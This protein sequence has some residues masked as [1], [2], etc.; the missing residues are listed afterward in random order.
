MQ[1]YNPCEERSFYGTL[2]SF[3]SAILRA[4]ESGLRSRF[5]H[6]IIESGHSEL[7]AVATINI[8]STR[9]IENIHYDNGTNKCCGTQQITAIKSTWR[10][11]LIGS[12]RTS[13]LDFLFCEEY[14]YLIYN[15]V[16]LL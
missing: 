9:D 6:M 1:N 8:T 16:S 12:V 11:Q 7:K 13:L 10:Y 5:D 3:G 4:S 14:L 15:V 2:L